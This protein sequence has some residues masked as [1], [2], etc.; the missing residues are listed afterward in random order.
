[1]PQQNLNPQTRIETVEMHTGGEPVRIVTSGYPEIPGATLLEKRRYAAENLDH[2]RRFIM[3]EPRGHSD[4]YG[5]LPV[6]PDIEG[7]DMAALFIHNEGYSTMCGHASIALGRYALDR[8]IIPIID[9]RATLH[10]QCPCGMVEVTTAAA[11]K[12]ASPTRSAFLSPPAFAFAL[13]QEIAAPGKGKIAIDIAYGGA[14]YAVLPA[15][16]L[17]LDVRRSS[18]R[19]LAEAAHQIT[20]AA[21]SA[22]RLEHPDSPELAF[23]YGTILTDGGSG[24]KEEG[25]STNICVFA[26]REIDRSPTGSGVTARIA[27]AAARH[28]IALGD[29]RVFESVTGAKFETILAEAQAA[30]PFPIVRVEVSGESYY[31]GRSVFTLEAGD[32]HLPGFLLR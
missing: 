12:E 5:V 1:M 26:D 24:K 10:L 30:T 6:A 28:E 22:I 27:L 16:R 32:P 31:T 20:L 14:F 19:D 17:D 29:R 7:A 23:L 2:Y 15:Q 9:G 4:M 8:G 3:W 18:T 21:K 11:K 13:S 25:P